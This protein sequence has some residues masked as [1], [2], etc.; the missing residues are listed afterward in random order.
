MPIDKEESMSGGKRPSRGERKH[1]RR[2]KAEAKNDAFRREN[3]IQKEEVLKEKQNSWMAL[4]TCRWSKGDQ[5]CPNCG[6]SKYNSRFGRKIFQEGERTF[7]S[8]NK[9]GSWYRL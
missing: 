2:K 8:C 3:Q 5:K 6:E 4:P 9:C 1:N 7:R